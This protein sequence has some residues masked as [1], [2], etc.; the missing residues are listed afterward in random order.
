MV[1]ESGTGRPDRRA[2]YVAAGLGVVGLVLGLW[3]F[4]ALRSFGAVSRAT[5]KNVEELT[6]LRGA[7]FESDGSPRKEIAFEAA[8]KY[9]SGFNERKPVLERLVGQLERGDGMGLWLPDGRRNL[10]ATVKDTVAREEAA[11]A[12]VA[13]AVNAVRPL[14]GEAVSML[15]SGRSIRANALAALTPESD[16]E[17]FAA[18]EQKLA[19]AAQALPHTRRKLAAAGQRPELADNAEL[20]RLAL[21]RSIDRSLEEEAGVLRTRQEATASARKQLL[22]YKAGV[23]EMLASTSDFLSGLNALGETLRPAAGRAY[24]HTE[25][26]RQLF[27]EAEEP[28]PGGEMLGV[29]GGMLSGRSGGTVTPLSIVSSIDPSFKVTVEVLKGVCDGVATVH[30]EVSAIVSTTQPLMGPI[31]EFRDSRSRRSMV[32]LANAAPETARFLQSKAPVFDPVL[33]QIERGRPYVSAI[34]ESAG[35]I[36]QRSAQQII[37]QCADIA[38]RLLDMAEE[39]FRQGRSAMVQTSAALEAMSRREQEYQASLRSLQADSPRQTHTPPTSEVEKSGLG[40]GSTLAATSAEEQTSLATDQLPTSTSSRG[41]VADD[42]AAEEM[43]T[44]D[45]VASPGPKRSHAGT[46]AMPAGAEARIGRWSV[47]GE[48]RFLSERRINASELAGLSKR[49]LKLLRNFVYAQHGRPFSNADVR[50]FFET[51]PWYAVDH[52]YTESRLSAIELTNVS[53]IKRVEEE[54][55]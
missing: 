49:D 29:F 24:Q 45:R 27:R 36:R 12:A 39:P 4:L 6:V 42:A 17:A 19:Q 10:A 14:N 50:S 13:S 5:T 3:Y 18:Q 54:S 15:A 55:D 25:P 53:T 9:L 7:L 33:G 16:V 41:A 26:L 40:V 44:T 31:G 48:L 51:Q 32:A 23:S 2:V 47:P 28:I 8:E 46:A 20:L 38:S 1:S 34:Y 11:A 43:V 37:T 22:D 30:G 21:I 35:R 52:A